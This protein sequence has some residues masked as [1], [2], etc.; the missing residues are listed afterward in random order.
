MPVPPKKASSS[1][2]TA[3][4]ERQ[5]QPLANPPIRAPLAALQPITVTPVPAMD[6]PIWNAT[7]ATLSSV[8]VPAGVWSPAT[9]LD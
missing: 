3:S 4:A 5:G 9:L 8:G 7:M 1:H 2:R 6:D